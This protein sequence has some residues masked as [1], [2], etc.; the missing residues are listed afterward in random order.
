MEWRYSTGLHCDCSLGEINTSIYP[1]WVQK[2]GGGGGPKAQGKTQK[3]CREFDLLC[4]NL[5]DFGHITSTTK[6]PS[7]DP[8]E[9]PFLNDPLWMTHWI[10][11]SWMIPSWMTHSDHP[12]ESFRCSAPFTVKFLCMLGLL[13]ILYLPVALLKWLRLAQGRDG[14]EGKSHSATW[15]NQLF[16]W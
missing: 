15:L 10:T 14:S 6:F 16:L 8:L 1:C 11:P 9:W 4:D 13:R 7:N 3:K 5:F 12:D 2:H